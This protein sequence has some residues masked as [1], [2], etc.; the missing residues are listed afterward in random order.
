MNNVSPEHAA[1]VDRYK[2]AALRLEPR[3][4]YRPSPTE[5]DLDLMEQ[6]FAAHGTVVYSFDDR[7]IDLVAHRFALA[8]LAEVRELRGLR[9]ASARDAA[10]LR[11]RADQ[12]EEER[13]MAL[14]SAEGQPGA[15]DPLLLYG[16]VDQVNSERERITALADKL[17]DVLLALTARPRPPVRAD[18]RIRALRKLA[19]SQKDGTQR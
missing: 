18:D 5:A 11:Q 3:D 17:A 6:L 10:Q 9:E 2:E 19:D 1:M 4:A 16:V 13:D 7:H 15:P 8:L 14:A 12:A